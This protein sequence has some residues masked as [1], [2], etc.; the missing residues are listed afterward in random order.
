MCLVDASEMEAVRAC[1]C[2]HTPHLRVR[3]GSGGSG[4]ETD[5]QGDIGTGRRD[6]RMC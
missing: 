3:R 6:A 4:E 1:D 2:A 5:R